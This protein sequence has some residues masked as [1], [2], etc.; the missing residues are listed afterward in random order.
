MK[1]EEVGRDGEFEDP[2]DWKNVRTATAAS[3]I[4]ARTGSSNGQDLVQSHSGG[5]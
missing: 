5:G 1:A 2:A 4:I 3:T